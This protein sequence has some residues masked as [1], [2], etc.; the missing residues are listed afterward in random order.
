LHV[1]TFLQRLDDRS[2]HVGLIRATLFDRQQFV[3]G[4]VELRREF[5]ALEPRVLTGLL[6]HVTVIRDKIRQGVVVVVRPL[7]LPV[8]RIAVVDPAGL[9]RVLGRLALAILLAV[10]VGSVVGALGLGVV[11]V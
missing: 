6:D 7:A 11:V 1:E 10:A 4:Q 5:V 9:R 8:A 3:L 2:R